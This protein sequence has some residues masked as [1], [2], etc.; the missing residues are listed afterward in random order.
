M[1]EVRI[2]ILE[3]IDAAGAAGDGHVL[4]AVSFPGHRLPDDS[5]RSLKLPQY[6]PC[7]SVDG[8]ELARERASKDQ[9][10]SRHKRPRPV[11]APETDLPFALAG[12]RIDGLQ[13]TAMLGV[14]VDRLEAE[15]AVG[16][17]GLELLKL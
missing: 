5:R 13:E 17:A 7:I 14:V 4:P 15:A 9:S 16:F 11:R 10:A 2:G 1:L 8:D 3:H 6:L 12:Q